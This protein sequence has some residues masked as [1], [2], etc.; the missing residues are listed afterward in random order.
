MYYLGL[1]T[2][3][4]T[5]WEQ[6][7]ICLVFSIFIGLRH[8][9]S[10]SCK[11]CW[12]TIISFILNL[13][14]ILWSP[15]HTLIHHFIGDLLLFHDLLRVS[16]LVNYIIIQLSYL[17]LSFVTSSTHNSLFF[18]STIESSIQGHSKFIFSHLFWYFLTLQKISMFTFPWTQPIFFRFCSCCIGY[19]ECFFLLL[20]QPIQ[21]CLNFTL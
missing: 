5:L 21:D 2:N 14:K 13:T 1:C 20:F 8:W 15:V 12:P 10:V 3:M 4:S 7:P 17:A 6:S 11:N 19:L 9:I 16:Q 18:I